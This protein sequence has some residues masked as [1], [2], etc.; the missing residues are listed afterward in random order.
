MKQKQKSF[1]EEEE[2]LMNSRVDRS[3]DFCGQMGVPWT[4]ERGTL[5]SF[6]DAVK[7]LRPREAEEGTLSGENIGSCVQSRASTFI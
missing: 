6:S 4:R 5:T 1:E 2:L 3:V 7:E